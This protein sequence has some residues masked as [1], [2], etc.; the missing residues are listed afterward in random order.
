MES[1]SDPALRISI[2][3]TAARLGYGTVFIPHTK[4]TVEDDH[5]PFIQAGIPSV[6]IIDLDY[7]YWHTTSDLPEHVSI[8]SL[9]TVGE[10]LWTWIAERPSAVK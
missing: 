8:R 7:P 9:Q 2:W 1:N 10:V 3:N 4:Y 5:L 6:D